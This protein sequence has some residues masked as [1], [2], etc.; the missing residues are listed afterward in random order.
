VRLTGLPPIWAPDRR[1]LVLGSMPGSV[2]LERQEY[3]AHPRNRFWRVMGEICGALPELSYR[4]RV[5]RLLRSGIALWDVL[6]HCVR[7]GS[8]DTNIVAGSE[9]PNDLVGLLKAN[10]S[11]RAVALNGGKAAQAFRRWI[12]PQLPAGTTGRVAIIDLPSTSPA[13][14]SWAPADLVRSWSRIAPYLEGADPE[15]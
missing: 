3:Y 2:S 13:N 10:G 8:L 7:E 14:A 4:E 12:L 6:Q 1:V 15:L 5:H 9:V 11:L